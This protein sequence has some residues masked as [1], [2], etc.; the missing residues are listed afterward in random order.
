LERR[1]LDNRTPTIIDCDCGL[2]YMR[3]WIRSMSPE[4]GHYRCACGD[5]LGAWN[6]PYRLVF[7]PEEA[8]QRPS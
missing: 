5:V 2:R 4:I 6:G 3:T 7:E 1:I 8:V